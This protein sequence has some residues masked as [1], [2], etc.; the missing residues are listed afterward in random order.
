M[1]GRLALGTGAIGIVEVAALSY[2]TSDAFDV[3]MSAMFWIVIIVGLLV[4]R[5]RYGPAKG[6]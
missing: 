1:F 2:F 4:A 6:E 5:S 3:G